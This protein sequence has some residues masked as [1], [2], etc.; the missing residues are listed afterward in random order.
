MITCIHTDS[1]THFLATCERMV[2]SVAADGNC[3]FRS[4]SY[5]LF[6]HEDEHWSLRTIITRFENLNSR[7]FEKRMTS[8]NGRTFSDHIQKLCHPSSWATHIEVLA[9]ATYFQAPVY[10]CTDP[11]KPSAGGAYC[12]EC[13]NPIASCTE[14]SY[15]LLTEPTL[16][17]VNK[18]QRFELAYYTNCHYNPIVSAYTRVLHET[19][20]QL[21]GEVSFHEHII[22]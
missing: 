11:P 13:Y 9:V 1:L 3:F 8:I 16:H 17:G 10:I 4:I 12:W 15:P 14:L 5:L 20:P 22:E 21:S 6:S 2:V 7:L 18:V 19:Q